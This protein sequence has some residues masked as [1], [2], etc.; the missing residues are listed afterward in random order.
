MDAAGI[1]NTRAES[2]S[3]RG[4]MITTDD[5]HFQTAFGK[6]YKEIIKQLNRLSRWNRL[7]IHITCND[8]SVGL[9]VI[10]NIDDLFEYI[11]LIFKH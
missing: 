11:F 4:V 2:N 10:Y 1:H 8:D 5:K 7:V 6:L 9:F 3:F